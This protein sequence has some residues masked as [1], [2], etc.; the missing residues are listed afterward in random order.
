MSKMLSGLIG[1]PVWCVSA[2]I[3]RCCGTLGCCFALLPC[4]EKMSGRKKIQR[5]GENVK[6]EETE[7]ELTAVLPASPERYN[8]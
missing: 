4:Y 6:P 7:R 5:R 8:E 2:S 3:A 1:E